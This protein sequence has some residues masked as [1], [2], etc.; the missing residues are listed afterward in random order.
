MPRGMLGLSMESCEQLAPVFGETEHSFPWLSEAMDLKKEKYFF[1]T[2]V[3]EYRTG[4]SLDGDRR[5]VQ[6]RARAAR[7]QSP[8]TGPVAPGAAR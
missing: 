5:P 8:Q 7:T 4:G 2:R 1:E 3:A 6:W